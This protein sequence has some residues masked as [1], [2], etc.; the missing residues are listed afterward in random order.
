VLASPD[1]EDVVVA[2]ADVDAALS[3]VAARYHDMATFDHDLAVNGLDRAVLRRALHRELRF[4][5]VMQRVGARAAAVSDIDVRLF[6]EVHHERFTQPETRSARHILVTVNDDY[7]ENTRPAALARLQTLADKLN[8]R[9]KRFAELAQRHSE[10]PTAMQGGSLG[11]VR[12]GMLYPAL[13]KMLFGMAPGEISPIVESDVGFHL[14]LCETVH[15][16][17]RLPLR[18]AAARIRATL[19]E[20]RRRNCQK[21]WLATLDPAVNG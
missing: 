8:G 13:D 20:R 12:R 7:A 3:A 21:A 10:C 11:R 2:D 16:A 6:Y 14:L 19:E 5:N 18:R 4:D 1:A 15:P 9:G 17:K